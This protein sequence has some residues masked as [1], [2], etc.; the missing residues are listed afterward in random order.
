MTVRTLPNRASRAAVDEDMAEALAEGVPP[1]REIEISISSEEPYRRA[2]SAGAPYLEILGHGADEVDL[3]RLNSGTAP[4]L[5]DHVNKLDSQIGQVRRAWVASGKLR[6]LVR[7]SQTPAADEILARVRAGDVTCVSVGYEI[8]RAVK[9]GKSE[10][11]TPIIRVT[12]WQPKEA[13]F[14]AVP[15]DASVGY[16]RAL[17]GSAGIEVAANSETPAGQPAQTEI[18]GQPAQSANPANPAGDPSKEDSMDKETPAIDAQASDSAVTAALTA[19]RSRAAA[20]DKIGGQ[21]NLGA[22]MIRAAVEAGTSVDAFRAQVMDHI[23]GE[24]GEAARRRS[25]NIGMTAQEID[26]FSIMRAVRFLTNPTKENRERAAFEIDAS[27][28][29]AK[30]LRRDPEGLMVPPD[31]LM[32]RGFARA[33]NVADPAAG[34]N[35]VAQDYRAGSFIDLLRKRLVLSEAGAQT[36]TGLVG[37][38]DIPKRLSG[39]GH[40]WVAEGEDVTDSESG[41]GLVSMSPHTVG[42]AVPMTRRMMQQGSPDIEALARFDMIQRAAAAIESAV[43]SDAAAGGAAPLSLGAQLEAGKVAFA[44][45]VPTFGEM[46]DLETKV[47]VEDAD[48]GSLAYI[49]GAAL[50]GK[51]KQSF[52][53]DGVAERIEQGGEVNGYR[54]L[55]SNHVANGRAYFGNWSDLLIGFW[56][57]LDLTVDTATLAKSGGVVLRAFQDVDFALR[58]KASFVKGVAGA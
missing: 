1:G 15:A 55:R 10:D 26:Q 34:G 52:V 42:I 17:D 33:Q 28:A 41:F 53:T 38:V 27:N 44:G 51:L 2:A 3:S 21:F 35:L 18:A 20:I 47:A 56:S 39:S 7:F 4:L 9:S 50:S 45:A 19:E 14:V 12:G 24:Q 32:S 6:A 11:G 29:A 37:D 43:L 49:Y 16:G 8:S 30:A 57:G 36:L 54:R 31:V 48:F 13:S 23:A 46:V 22:D 5:K 25:A 58:H 40:Y